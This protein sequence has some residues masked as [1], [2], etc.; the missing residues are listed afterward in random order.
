MKKDTA[1][2]K[3]TPTPRKAQPELI[4]QLK[5]TTNSLASWLAE[6]LEKSL[7]APE[8]LAAAQAQ[9]WLFGAKGSVLAMLVTL[10]DIAV[11]LEKAGNTAEPMAVA[12][13]GG[14]GVPAGQRR[15]DASEPADGSY[16]RTAL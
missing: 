3:K 10:V 7:P 16:V 5:E 4:G 13:A 1:A 14:Q 2:F 11:V 15:L 9:D 8:K 6:S 12:E